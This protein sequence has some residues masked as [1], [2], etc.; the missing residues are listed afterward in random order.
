MSSVVRIRC[1]HLKVAG[2]AFLLL[3]EVNE[4]CCREN[5]DWNL[6]SSYRLKYQA[7][8]IP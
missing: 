3:E 5:T 7:W 8:S 4:W 1:Q 6:K 2:V